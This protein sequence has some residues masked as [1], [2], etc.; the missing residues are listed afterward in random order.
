[1]SVAEKV[2]RAE[3]FPAALRVQTVDAARARGRETLV[4]VNVE[5]EP[6]IPLPLRE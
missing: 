6:T 3:W 4:E 2:V 5:E 1:M